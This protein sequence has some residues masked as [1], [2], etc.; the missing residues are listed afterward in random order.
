MF[1][2]NWVFLQWTAAQ[3]PESELKLNHVN[4]GLY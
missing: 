3:T 2:K 4:Y 1:Q